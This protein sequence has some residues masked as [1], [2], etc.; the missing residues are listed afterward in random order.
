MRFHVDQ[1]PDDESAMWQLA[2]KLQGR[3]SDIVKI[4]DA[5][6]SIDSRHM[7]EFRDGIEWP[8]GIPCRR[9]WGP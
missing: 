1:L 8:L 5:I 9:A 4:Q 7:A 3:S 2:D 6:V